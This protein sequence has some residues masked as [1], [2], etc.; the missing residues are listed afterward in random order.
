MT[1]I[2][3]WHYSTVEKE[4]FTNHEIKIKKGDSIY[5][6]SDGYV[7]QFGGP[8][9]TKFKSVNLKKL[10]IEMNPK[11]MTE[12]KLILD[13]KFNNWKGELDQID[14]IIFIGIKF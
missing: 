8:A 11:P 13:A 7:D 10:L 4:K 9:Q 3:L 5:L 14:D 12:Q 1:I 2:S 6:F